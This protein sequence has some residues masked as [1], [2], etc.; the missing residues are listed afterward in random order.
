MRIVEPSGVQYHF[1]ARDLALMF[2]AS[3]TATHPVTRRQLLPTEMRRVGRHLPLRLRV[4]FM[5]TLKHHEATARAARQEDSLTSFLHASAGAALDLVISSSEADP[6]SSSDLYGLLDDYEQAIM[7][8][9]IRFPKSVRGLLQQHRS[10]MDQRKRCC[11][12]D[13]IDI[14]ATHLEYLKAQ[15][16]DDDLCSSELPRPAFV[17]WILE[18]VR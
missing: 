7:D 14:V 11:D 6:A 5:Q 16:V 8:V 17:N 13:K 12:K 4:L 18:A 10:L 1:K 3:A 15:Y 9:A 2:V